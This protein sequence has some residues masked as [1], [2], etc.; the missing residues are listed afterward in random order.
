MQDKIVSG[1]EVHALDVYLYVCFM[2]KI[3]VH[4]C[5]ICDDVGNILAANRL[6]NSYI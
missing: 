4:V 1:G 2:L 5:F 6:K 3:L